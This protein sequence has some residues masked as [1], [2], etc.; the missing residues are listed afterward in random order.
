MARKKKS[1]TQKANPHKFKKDAPCLL[2]FCQLVLLPAVKQG[3][4]RGG[5]EGPWCRYPKENLI[6]FKICSKRRGWAGIQN[7]KLPKQ[8]L[9]QKSDLKLWLWQNLTRTKTTWLDMDKPDTA[10]L[11]TWLSCWQHYSY[12]AYNTG[13]C[14]PSEKE[15]N[16][17]EEVS[18]L[19]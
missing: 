13:Q 12:N 5:E 19:V 8:N 15:G 9:K 6:Y 11:R 18:S 14:C 7:S 10:W 1:W 3:V 4:W 17:S 2:A 16:Q